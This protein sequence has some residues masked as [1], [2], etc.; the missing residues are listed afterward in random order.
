MGRRWPRAVSSARSAD[1]SAPPNKL[2]R[3]GSKK[4]QE[5]L[6]CAWE[7]RSGACP[8]DVGISFSTSGTPSKWY[9]A[10]HWFALN[11]EDWAGG[12]KLLEDALANI[13]K[14]R[15]PPDWRLAAMKEW[16]EKHQKG[17]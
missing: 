7:S 14:Y 17:S 8:L 12:E 1:G 3:G 10:G 16:R 13:D 15:R 11:S 2:E 9:C 6:R 4:V 5:R